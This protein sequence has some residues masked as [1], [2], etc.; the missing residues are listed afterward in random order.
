MEIRAPLLRRPPR[1]KFLLPAALPRL[2]P[3]RPPAPLGR[4][5]PG[6]PAIPERKRRFP[7]ATCPGRVLIPCW[8]LRRCKGDTD[9]PGYTTNVLCGFGQVPEPR[10][11]HFLLCKTGKLLP[12]GEVVKIKATRQLYSILLFFFFFQLYPTHFLLT[13]LEFKTW[14]GL[15]TLQ[16]T[17]KVISSHPP[18][19]L[20]FFL[21]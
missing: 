13:V 9:P 2:E 17:V 11:I 18:Y 20:S 6:F 3:R 7:A 14:V 16:V 1:P 4:R 21:F 19:I 10:G 12:Y 5:P 8:V 15:L